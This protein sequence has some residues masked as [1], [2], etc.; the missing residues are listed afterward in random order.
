MAKIIQSIVRGQ[1]FSET[2]TLQGSMPLELLYEIG[3]EK[4]QRDYFYPILSNL[5][6]TKDDMEGIMVETN[7]IFMLEKLHCIQVR[8]CKQTAAKNQN[9]LT[10]HSL[11]DEYFL[12]F[13]P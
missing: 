9:C 4:L 3:V 13:F 12:Y 6:A 5:L 8:F 1:E 7:K 11:I 10:F 2:S